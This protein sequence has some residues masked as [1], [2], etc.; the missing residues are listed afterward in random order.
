MDPPEKEDASMM[1]SLTITSLRAKPSF[2]AGSSRSNSLVE[3]QGPPSAM[4]SLTQQNMRN[5][6]DGTT[7]LSQTNQEE[8]REEASAE[9]DDTTM[10]VMPIDDE[11]AAPALEIQQIPLS[12]YPGETSTQEV[13]LSPVSQSIVDGGGDN[14]QPAV[15]NDMSQEVEFVPRSSILFEADRKDEDED[16]WRRF[17]IALSALVLAGVITAIVVSIVNHSH[18][19]RRLLR[20]LREC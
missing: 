8:K 20:R 18:Q 19:E 10:I 15:A 9:I 5:E 11:C 17:Y 3:I 1:S 12:A 4:S 2:G 7:L 13:G 14:A 6:H 16:F